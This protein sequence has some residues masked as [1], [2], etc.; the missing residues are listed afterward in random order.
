MYSEALGSIPALDILFQTSV[1]RS[2]EKYQALFVTEMLT[3]VATIEISLMT[4]L[5][6]C[7]NVT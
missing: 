3:G 5:K 6:L 2:I 7:Q 1:G 4:P